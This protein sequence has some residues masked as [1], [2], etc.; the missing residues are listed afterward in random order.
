MEIFYHI[1]LSRKN[2]NGSY[3]KDCMEF[4]TKKIKPNFKYEIKFFVKDV[5]FDES[6]FPEGFE[7]VV[8]WDQSLVKLHFHLI[9]NSDCLHV[10]FMKCKSS[11]FKNV[12]SKNEPID[13]NFLLFNNMKCIYLRPDK[14]ETSYEYDTIITDDSYVYDI[15]R[16]INKHNT[17]ENTCN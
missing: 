7:H 16:I 15:D 4:I 9:E 10:V 2:T 14:D 17:N 12:H 5:D 8:I 11:I 13:E 6:K 3:I 1:I